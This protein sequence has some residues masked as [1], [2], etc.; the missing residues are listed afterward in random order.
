MPQ[1]TFDEKSTMVQVMTWCRHA[2]CPS[3]PEPML[4]Q[5]YVAIMRHQVT[6]SWHYHDV[7]MSTMASQITSLTD[8]LHS[9]LFRRRSKKTTRLSVTGLCAANSPVTGEF[10]IQMASNAENVSISW[11]HHHRKNTGTPVSALKIKQL[12]MQPFSSLILKN[13]FQWNLK[14]KSYIFIQENAFENVVCEMATILARPQC[15]KLSIGS[16]NGLVTNMR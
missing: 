6:V 10:P 7:I 2:T 16:G 3:L 5:I 14:Q 13:K 9:H 12:S 11:R 8:C 1:H 15:V 4:I